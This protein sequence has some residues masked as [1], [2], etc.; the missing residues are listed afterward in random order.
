MRL[1]ND[2]KNCTGTAIQ[3]VTGKDMQA[4]RYEYI[5]RSHYVFRG[6]LHV[7]IIIYINN[8]NTGSCMAAGYRNSC[9]LADH[10]TYLGSSS[11]CHCDANC[12]L[13]EDCCS[14]VAQDCEE[15]GTCMI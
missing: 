13:F 11:T 5:E 4:C 8:T 3:T 14:D 6:G 15:Q 1:S 12:R 9:C 2:E 7:H 10:Q